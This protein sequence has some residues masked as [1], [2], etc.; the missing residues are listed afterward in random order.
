MCVHTAERYNEGVQAV[1]LPLGVE[2]GQN[3]GVVRCLTHWRESE[4]RER[5]TGK[6]RESITLQWIHNISYVS[7]HYSNNLIEIIWQSF[8][9]L[10]HTTMRI[11]SKWSDLVQ[12]CCGMCFLQKLSSHHL[13]GIGL[14]I[15][16]PLDLFHMLLHYSHS[17]MD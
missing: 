11:S 6:A 15:L 3:Y 1:T 16:R 8:K 7:S 5:R 17:K 12:Q 4:K 2:L 13:L 9:S 14:I 10:V